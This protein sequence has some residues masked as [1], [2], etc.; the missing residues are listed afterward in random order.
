M[1]EGL[2][3]AIRQLAQ[4]R[5]DPAGKEYMCLD[6]AETIA[7]AERFQCPRRTVEL[8]A[9]EQRIIPE[10]YQRNIGTVGIDG[11]MR[12]LRS[13]VGVVGAGGLGGL[14]IELLARMGIGS[15]V[16]IDGDSFA[17][18]NLNR[19]LLTLEGGLGAG[20]AETAAR[21]VKEINGAVEILPLQQQADA[22]NLVASLAGCDLALDCLD[23]LATRFALEEACGR[24]AIPLVHGAIAGFMGQ[25]AVIEPGRPL[26]A[27]IYGA[28]PAGT[29]N[30]G[31]GVETVLGNPA[32]TPAMLAAWQVNEAVKILAGL[33]SGLKDKLLIIDMLSGECTTVPFA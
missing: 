18:S 20:K 22:S 8:T 10:R 7:L 3:D 31:R 28:P 6:L 24:L 9:L 27:K 30:V 11:Q 19:Q 33:E 2:K 26:F 16:V 17:A 5:V 14:A 4:K 25:L 32:T 13:K 12:L 15:L 1:H 21:R 23:N 29:G